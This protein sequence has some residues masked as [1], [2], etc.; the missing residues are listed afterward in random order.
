MTGENGSESTLRVIARPGNTPS[1]TLRGDDDRLCRSV[2]AGGS[3]RGGYF[4]PPPS[5][6]RIYP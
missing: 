6:M 2:W 5:K 4:A 3:G 1:G